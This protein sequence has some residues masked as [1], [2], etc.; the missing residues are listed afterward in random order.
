MNNDKCDGSLNSRFSLDRGER[1]QYGEGNR[2][3]LIL[4]SKVKNL[5][6]QELTRFSLSYTYSGLVRAVIKSEISFPSKHCEVL[7]T[8]NIQTTILAEIM[9]SKMESQLKQLRGSINLVVY[10][11]DVRPK[12]YLHNSTRVRRLTHHVAQVFTIYR[13]NSEDIK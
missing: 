9:N 4:A 13:R 5:S 6:R 11:M 3:A 2:E 12:I 10:P 7:H 8:S 1:S